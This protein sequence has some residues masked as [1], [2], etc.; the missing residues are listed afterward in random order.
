MWVVFQKKEQKIVGFT[1]NGAKDLEKDLALQEVVSGLVKPGDI[2]EYDA[3]QVTDRTK[4]AE[5]LEAFPDKLVVKGTPAEPQL[6]IRD[7]ETFSLY[8]TTDAKDIHP[9]DGISEIKAD[10]ESFA[11]ITVQVID[12]RY[13]PH[14]GRHGAGQI[15]LRTD[16]GILRDEKGE[17]DINAITL[18]D[19]KAIFRLV[20]EKV[21]R[22][23]TIQML[24]TNLDLPD[25]SYRIE[26]I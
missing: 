7:P 23:A 16:H 6:T 19:G 25:T 11:T 8:I 26:F 3:I 12:D 18:K 17:K 4:A 2:S 14:R 22:V 20:S 21:K 9:V 13:K 1:A 15:Y 10:G 24:S 5:Y